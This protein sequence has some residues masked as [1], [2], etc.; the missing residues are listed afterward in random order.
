MTLSAQK[1]L[2]LFAF[3]GFFFFSF[4]QPVL[5]QVPFPEIPPPSL[6]LVEA[7]FSANWIP[8]AT[9]TEVGKNAERARQFLFWVLSHPSV[10][11]APVLAQLWSISRNIVYLFLVLTLVAI[12]FSFMLFRRRG[13]GPTFSGIGPLNFSVNLP[14]FLVK[15][16]TLLLFVTLSYV[17][18]LGLIQIGDLLM[19]FLVEKVGGKDLFNIIFAGLNSEKNYTDF[20]GFRDS[21]PAQQESVNTSLFLIRVT[22]LTYNLMALLLILRKIILWFLLIVSPFLAILMPFLFIRNI[23][24]LWI[25]TFFQWLFY[26]P[27]LALFLA[28]LA[29]VWGASLPNQ[30][31]GIPYPFD[32]SRIDKPE[33]QIFKTSIN[34]LIGGPGQ[35]LSP[36]NSLNYV[37][38]YA[39]YLIALLML[40]AVMF[41]P[42]LLLRIFR[43]YCCDVFRSAQTTMAA[44]YDRFRGVSPP[45]PPPPPPGEK[46]LAFELPFRHF[47]TLPQ[48]ISLE[49]PADIQRAQTQQIARALGL[50]ITSLQDISQMEIDTAQRNL[51]QI[52]LAKL[53]SP[54]KI[55]S[56]KEREK[57]LN[58]RS[59]ILAR[60]Q[61]GDRVAQRIISATQKKSEEVLTRVPEVM[62][63]GMIQPQVISQMA[64][65]TG[66]SQEKVSEIIRTLPLVSA[67]EPNRTLLISQRVGLPQ[68]EVRKVLIALPAAFPQVVAP[69]KAPPVTIEDYE[70]VKRMWTNHYSQ[71]EVPVSE[72]IKTRQDWLKKDIVNLSNTLNLLQSQDLKLK[73]KGL[74]E[75]ATLLP[76]LLLGGFSENETR[77][78]L[79]AKLEAAHQ[80]SEELEKEEKVKTEAK[81]EVEEELVEVPVKVKEAKEKAQ[82]AAAKKEEPGK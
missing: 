51:V 49:K 45:P 37:D 60:S 81:K 34:I 75:V 6:Q 30:I 44:L 18:I 54:E 64:Q 32:F 11:N 40:W 80:V 9:V 77:V 17:L 24:W 19:K 48:R 70:E 23:G 26:G 71:A 8:D 1:I 42:W 27:L 58:L 28:S 41:L 3:L 61:A 65:K 43:D 50:T 13:L 46:G 52:N 69:K 62:P 66:L 67:Q 78:Y 2:P 16:V 82:E 33:G 59:E 36:T 15:T 12:G 55:E 57:F 39:E 79:Q 72:K 47:I 63:V 7:T 74:E 4:P 35:K 68:E 38:T 29:K 10:D 31:S 25:G 20:V 21:N 73:K 22:T 5:G 14:N 76:F 53:T 56:L